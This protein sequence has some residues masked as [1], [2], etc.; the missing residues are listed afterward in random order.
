MEGVKDLPLTWFSLPVCET[1]KW[2]CQVAS[3]INQHGTQKSNLR[4]CKQFISLPCSKSFNSLSLSSGRK[5]SKLIRIVFFSIH[6][7]TTFL[8]IYPAMPSKSPMLQSHWS[9]K[10]TIFTT[11][12][13]LCSYCLQL[14]YSFHP[15]LSPIFFCLIMLLTFRGSI[16]NPNPLR[17]FP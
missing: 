7:P 15:C 5:I 17:S 4:K 13:L 2:E 12:C 10:T 16:Q 8:V 1:S 9:L 3:W 6:D 14:V 11:M